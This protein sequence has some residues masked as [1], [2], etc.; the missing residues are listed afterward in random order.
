MA[1]RKVNMNRRARA[2]RATTNA[3]AMFDQE[4][5]RE[6]KEAFNMLDQNHDGFI[7]S[8]NL[9]EILISFGKENP[10]EIIETMLAEVPGEK[11][12]FTMFLTMFAEKLRGTDP[13]DVLHGA[14]LCFDDDSSGVIQVEEFRRVLTTMGDKYTEEQVEEFLRDAPIKDGK[15]DYVEFI[16]QL[17]NGVQDDSEA[18]KKTRFI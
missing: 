18:K 2:Q 4:Q 16:R 13:V 6:F 14:F 9:R 11:L 17:K 8:Y 1:S 10:D 7:D 12:N 5:I 15:F 3:L